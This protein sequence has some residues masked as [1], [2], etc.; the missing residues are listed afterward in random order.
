MKI[1]KILPTLTCLLL[2]TSIVVQANHIISEEASD[3]APPVTCDIQLAHWNFN[4]CDAIIGSTAN[5][6]SEFNGNT[7]NGTCSNVSTT[8]VFR[9]NP[10]NYPHSCTPGL[11]GTKAMCVSSST[12]CTFSNNSS[13]AIRFEVTLNPGSGQQATLG[14]LQFYEKAPYD[15][16]W[17]DGDS[18]LNNRPTKY[19]VRVTKNGQEIFKQTGISTTTSFSLE[20]FDFQAILI[21]QLVVQLLSNSNFWVI[22]QLITDLLLPY[23]TL[24]I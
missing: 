15:Y 18:G 7:N 13:K 23:G 2:W 10:S 6:Y 17:I 24:K 19:G 16:N 9:N 20:S 3:I 4:T 8:N 11:N 21:L 22:V 12:S 5:S 14:T 1:N